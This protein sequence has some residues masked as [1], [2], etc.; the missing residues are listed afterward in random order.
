MA[1]DW[2]GFLRTAPACGHAVQVYA[3]VSE[4]AKSVA[5]YLS[6]GFEQGEP[7]VV[8]ATPS[9]W[10]AFASALGWDEANGKARSLL[11]YVDAEDT[12]AA[13]LVD[14]HPS[15]ERMAS[16][17]GSLIDSIGERHPGRRIRAFGEMVDILTQGGRSAE[18][19]ELERLWND[20]ARKRDFALL[21]GYALDVFDPGAQS[22]LLPQVCSEHSH[23]LPAVDPARFTRSVD[24]AL[25]EV[26][27]SREAGRLYV[28]VGEQARS[29]SIPMGQLA[30]MW[31]S[32]HM[33]AT[34]EHVFASARAHYE[35]SATAA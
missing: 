34:A 3:N 22:G 20:L 10:A 27:G 24:L 18:A 2:E 15:A 14:G 19:I 33:P 11:T 5:S 25:D 13:L 32:R 17:V 23:V 31:I 8:V 6:A 29:K 9:H 28:L 7:A 30:L 35:H 21:C 1:E 4:L 16:V 12:L 26:L